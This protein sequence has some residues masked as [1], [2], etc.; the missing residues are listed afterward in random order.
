M[1]HKQKE[2]QEIMEESEWVRMHCALPAW[3]SFFSLTWKQKSTIPF[4]FSSVACLTRTHISVVVLENKALSDLLQLL[5]LTTVPHAEGSLTVFICCWPCGVLLG[6]GKET[7][8]INFSHSFP[9]FPFPSSQSWKVVAWISVH[10]LNYPWE[11]ALKPD[12]AQCR[13]YMQALSKHV[14]RQSPSG[15]PQ[16][17]I[18]STQETLQTDHVWYVSASS[19]LALS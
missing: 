1:P 10:R 9:L 14:A 7:E 8:P 15:V 17:W 18:K 2:E 16:R 4:S 19:G 11:E 12:P 13:L 5:H 3:F 6:T